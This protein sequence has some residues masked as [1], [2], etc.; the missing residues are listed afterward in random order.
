M[1][2]GKTLASASG[3]R[4]IR[5]WDLKTHQTLRTLRGDYGELYA[6]D[7]SPDGRWMASGSKEGSVNLWDLAS[8]TN[9][10]P[11]YRRLPGTNYLEELSYSSD[12]RFFGGLL[13][14]HLLLFQTATPE[15]IEAE[16]PGTNITDFAFAPN[17]LRL[18]ATDDS[19]HLG[20]WEIP[21]MRVITNFAAHANFAFFIG[22]GFM[23]GG[24]SVLT[25]D[26]SCAAKEWDVESWRE[27]HRFQLDTNF[28]PLAISPGADVV[29]TLKGDEIE[30]FSTRSPESRRHFTGQTRIGD[31]A[32]SPDGRTLASASDSG[33]V[34]LWDTAT[35]TRTAAL[36]GVLLGYHAVAFS[37]D[38]ERLAAG[39][40]GQEAIK[41]WDLHSLEE[42]ATLPG[43][44]SLFSDARFSPDGNTIVARNRDYW[45]AP[46]WNEINAAERARHR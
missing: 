26:E 46:S 44:G 14:G 24:R 34:E 41:I 43:Q 13:N 17:S 15:Q 37:P 25:C 29:A 21:S 7:V 11:A 27:I 32:L 2:D 23:N 19:G 1:P 22:T 35:G 36:R 20:L 28:S 40:N 31:I 10:P 16:L 3:D 42:V 38:G 33:T 39:S 45:S 9:R 5:L 30:V 12:G 18:A 4:T 6:L 8:S